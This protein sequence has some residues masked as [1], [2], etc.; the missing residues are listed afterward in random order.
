MGWAAR[1]GG[2]TCNRGALTSALLPPTPRAALAAWRSAAA[3]TSGACLQCQTMLGECR[4]EEG[5]SACVEESRCGAAMRQGPTQQSPS[6]TPDDV[7][8]PFGV[9]GKLAFLLALPFLTSTFE[10]K[11]VVRREPSA[12]PCGQAGVC[13]G[14]Y[15]ASHPMLHAL[16]HPWQDLSGLRPFHRH[17]EVACFLL[18]ASS[19]PWRRAW[20]R[21]MRPNAY[22]SRYHPQ[23]ETRAT[24]MHHSRSNITPAHQ[25]RCRAHGPRSSSSRGVLG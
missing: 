4:G 19:P 8:L 17:Q 9:P 11:Y 5:V 18:L 20:L 16:Q 12:R 2:H 21:G 7:P 15:I 23:P 1:T 14:W 13:L 25:A 10:F 6:R 22:A 24:T 3:P